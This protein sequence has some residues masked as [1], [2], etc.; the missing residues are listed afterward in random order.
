[1]RSTVGGPQTQGLEWNA[2]ILRIEI[3]PRVESSAESG[4]R[5][6]GRR[7]HKYVGKPNL[8]GLNQQSIKCKATRNTQI[9]CRTDDCRNSLFNR[10]L[11]AGGQV[12]LR[13][14]GK[15]LS[16]GNSRLFIEAGAKTAMRQ[17]IRVEV[18]AF[19]LRQHRAAMAEKLSKNIQIGGSS[20]NRHPLHL[21][22]VGSRLVA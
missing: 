20:G 10:R 19:H 21:V 8:K 6:A 22:L 2:L 12:D 3:V 13:L 4:S 9:S 17:T 7:L 14:L 11:Q 1:M 16:R 18:A 5:I 15:R